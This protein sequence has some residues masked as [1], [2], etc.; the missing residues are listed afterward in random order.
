MG[1]KATTRSGVWMRRLA[2]RSAIRAIMV[3][4]TVVPVAVHSARNRVFQATPQR[5][6]PARHAR[7]QTRSLPMRWYSAM[8]DQWPSSFRKAPYRALVTGNA[9]NMTS[10]TEHPTTAEAMNRSPLKK[11]RRA[12]PKAKIITS[13]S[14]ATKAP[15]PMPN[16]L[17]ASAPQ[18]VL[19]RSNDQPLAPIMKPLA[20][21][22]ANPSRPPA[23]N[24]R[25]CALPGGSVRP[26][27]ARASPARPTSSQVRP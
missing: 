1:S 2:L 7:P 9:M 18:A 25:P 4:S 12:T 19:R 6:P 15:M 5:T 21:R 8:T 11:P 14:R 20:T 16:W 22:P 26:T 17:T 27:A 13:A 10:S 24:H 3:P 23:M